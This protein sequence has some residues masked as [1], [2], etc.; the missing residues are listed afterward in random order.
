MRSTTHWLYLLIALTAPLLL[1]G[2]QLILPTF[3]DWNTLSSPNYDPE[4]PKYFLP[5]A[6]F[7]R[8]FDALFGYISALDYRLFPGLNHLCI[9]AGHLVNT[10]LVYRLARELQFNEPAR[11]ISTVLFY[12]S[13]C[14]LATV[15]ACDSLNQTYSQLYGLALILSYLTLSGRKKYVV[16]AGLTFLAALAKENGLAWAVVPPVLAFGLRRLS[17]REALRD[18]AFGL[19]VAAVYAV[20]RLSLPHS[21][22]SN[23]DYE[24][25]SLLRRMMEIALMVVNTVAAVDVMSLVH[26]PSRNLP[27]GLLTAL[28]SAPFAVLLLGRT[29]KVWRSRTFLTLLV[30]AVIAVLP[31]LIFSLSMMNA[32]APLGML[33]LLIGYTVGQ[34]NP[35]RHSLTVFFFYVAAAMIVD[36][37]YFHSSWKTSLVGKE[38]AQE[39]IRQTGQP[40]KKA[41]CIL[42]EDEEQKF[43]SFYVTPS[44]AIGWGIAVMH[45]TGYRWPQDIK[46]T[47]ISRDQRPTALPALTRQAFSSGY[48]C[49]WIVDGKQISVERKSKH[50]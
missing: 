17:R 48:E 44:D 37:H 5:L 20:V 49:V 3:D 46:D 34:D 28:L 23:P 50:Q 19:G 6:S 41:Y 36:V 10:L 12:L 39:I 9:C 14:M 15:L 29:L 11:C 2:T 4:W 31:N 40:V 45:E 22:G 25:F 24:D 38:M 21:G 47:L 26:A 1:W 7:W 42:I 33:A 43:S 18:L 32:Y 30:C 13:P 35:Y 27:L 16:W 8:P